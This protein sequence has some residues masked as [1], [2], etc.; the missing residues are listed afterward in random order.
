MKTLAK[1]WSLALEYKTGKE[2]EMI[3]AKVSGATLRAH[4]DF[5]EIDA[6]GLLT[7]HIVDEKIQYSNIAEISFKDA[8]IM[9]KGYIHFATFRPD[10]TYFVVKGTLD[11]LNAE[12]RNHFIFST[13]QSKQLKVLKEHIEKWIAENGSGPSKKS[14]GKVDKDAQLKALQDLLNA[15]LI[16]QEDFEKQSKL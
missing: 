9:V 6:S 10:G 14:A 12:S 16:S 3:E 15:G 8:T 4:E 1:D 7:K 11:S 13:G 5:L 2:D